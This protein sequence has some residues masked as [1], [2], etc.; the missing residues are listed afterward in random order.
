MVNDNIAF[1]YDDNIS[2][3]HGCGVTISGQFWY[4][5]GKRNSQYIRQVSF[6]ETLISKIIYFCTGANLLVVKCNV[7][8]IYHL[9]SHSAHAILFNCQ[10]KKPY[11]ASI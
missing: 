11:Y 3:D 7:K 4:L 6:Q 10:R 5:G 9:I 8:Q 1:N 2:F